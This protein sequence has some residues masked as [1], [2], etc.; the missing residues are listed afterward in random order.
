MKHQ[1]KMTRIRNRYA[2]EVAKAWRTN[3]KCY[4]VL[5]ISD[6]PCNLELH[7]KRWEQQVDMRSS[8]HVSFEMVGAKGFIRSERH[9]RIRKDGAM[10]A[11]Q[12]E[13]L[14][15]PLTVPTY[16]SESALWHFAGGI[17]FDGEM[18]PKPGRTTF[19]EYDA[20]TRKGTILVTFDGKLL[21]EMHEQF[22][23]LLQDI[24]V[25]RDGEYDWMC[26]NW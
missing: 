24:R 16:D 15:R 18:I 26:A 6:G 17:V 13:A 14:K 1:H 21:P 7:E 11:Q 3:Q 19:C 25:L 8:M 20:R 5:Q 23:Q 10:L 9:G 22:P 4:L 2:R 12:G